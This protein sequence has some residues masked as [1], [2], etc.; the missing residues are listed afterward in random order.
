M[1]KN[2]FGEIRATMGRFIAIFAIVALGAG[3]YA[4]IQ[5]T[6]PDMQNSADTYFDEYDLMDARIVSTL[7]FSDSDIDYFKSMDGVERVWATYGWT[8]LWR[9]RTTAS[10]RSGCTPIPTRA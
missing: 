9:L 2:I 3:F 10:K 5:A 1:W 6:T 7:G 8:C 4:G